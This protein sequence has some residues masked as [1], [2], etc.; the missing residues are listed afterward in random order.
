MKTLD[1]LVTGGRGGRQPSSRLVGVDA[2]RGIA[3]LAMMAVHALYV[4]GPDGEPTFS[5]SV[6]AG[7]SAAT[8]AV[9]AGVGIAFMTRRDRVSSPGEGRAAAASLT[10]RALAIGLVGLAL[11]YT[12][13]GIGAV[14]L[15]Y[16]AVLFLLAIPLVFLRTRTLVAA[17]C[18]IAV[19]V[20]VLSHLVR[21]ALPE[22]RLGNPGFLYLL[23]DPGGLLAELTL[24]GYYPAL[25]WM[26]YICAG[27]VVGRLRLSSVRVA[28]G[29]LGGGLA[30]AAAASGV[31][32]LLMGP[33]GGRE[34]I[35]ASG[36]GAG[37]VA[38]ILT[39]GAEGTTP[40]STWWWL[41]TDAPHASTP[42]DLLHTAGSAVA[43][44]GGMLL[45]THA[46]GPKLSKA[47]QRVVTPLAVAGAM[48]LTIYTAHIVFMNS[49]L[50]VFGAL[51]GY[52]VQVTVALAFALAW[53]ATVGRG[54][55]ETVVARAAR[56]AR[57]AVT[58][59]SAAE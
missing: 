52:L 14:I 46:T 53:G 56:R 16:Y 18:A 17:G 45:L 3:L 47:F 24:T 43:L 30:V 6:S 39:F 23:Q 29:L 34:G 10:A 49:P 58:A 15:P 36:T 32:W 59:P 37:R 21:G 55:L 4:Y 11:G 44:L 41:A 35:A 51:T 50:D 25:P 7:R 8:F 1:T 2:T 42:P 28:A 31:S 13:A 19:V 48:P 12:Q 27:L 5:Y 26:A 22:P 33:L 40:T 20:P 38:Q 54:P 57:R 9:L